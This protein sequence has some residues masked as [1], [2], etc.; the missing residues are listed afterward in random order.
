L[1]IFDPKQHGI[2]HLLGGYQKSNS[3][4][5]TDI[6][7]VNERRDTKTALTGFGGFCNGSPYRTRLAVA[8]PS[9]STWKFGTFA[10]KYFSGKLTF[11]HRQI[12]GDLLQSKCVCTHDTTVGVNDVYRPRQCVQEIREWLAH[13]SHEGRKADGAH[14]V[15]NECRVALCRFQAAQITTA[16]EANLLHLRHIATP[17]SPNDQLSSHICPD[18]MILKEFSNKIALF[19][20][21]TT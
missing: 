20:T 18:D 17:R 16:I 15:A 10:F 14:T 9:A 3:H 11:D 7:E 19:P 13:P 2:I 1:G 5:L 4:I 8:C 6:R 21:K 12:L